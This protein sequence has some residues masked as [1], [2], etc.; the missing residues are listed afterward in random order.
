LKFAVK[1]GK[2]GVLIGFLREAAKKRES[3]EGLKAL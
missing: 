2:K 1:L 3:L